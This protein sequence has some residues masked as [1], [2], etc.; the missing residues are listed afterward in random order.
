M[1]TQ[2]CAL[3]PALFRNDHAADTRRVR[4]RTNGDLA[5][6][7][8]RGLETRSSNF[9]RALRTASRDDPRSDALC[10]DPQLRTSSAT[11]RAGRRRGR[12]VLLAPGNLSVEFAALARP[13]PK[14][15]NEDEVGPGAVGDSH[16]PLA[17]R[18][19]R[20]RP[21]SQRGSGASHPTAPPGDSL[22]DAPEMLEMRLARTRSHCGPSWGR[23]HARPVRRQRSC[24]PPP[25]MTHS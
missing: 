23:T 13:E 1:R 4:C 10:G 11:A 15:V 21:R 9:E 19:D 17:V 24:V 7:I 6:R 18:L 25:A 3:R 20:L 8:R 16:P 22:F 2:N 5:A 14:A 12:S